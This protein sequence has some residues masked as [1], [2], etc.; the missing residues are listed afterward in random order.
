MFNNKK[1]D[2][3]DG[4]FYLVVL[5]TIGFVYIVSATLMTTLNTDFQNNPSIT[6]QGK[7]MFASINGRFITLLDNSFTMIFVGLLLAIIVGAWFIRSHPAF[8][9]ITIPL[10]V[11]IIFLAAIYGNFFKQF[12]ETPGFIVATSQ[13]SILTFV[14]GN[15][16]KIITVMVLLLALVLYAKNVRSDPIQ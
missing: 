7:T 13:F 14:M 11:F 15:F 1:G 12:S 5:F 10:M 9:W 2:W 16:V 4:I 6:P 8:F 3:G